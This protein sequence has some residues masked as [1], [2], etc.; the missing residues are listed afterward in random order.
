MVEDKKTANFRNIIMLGLVS[1]FIDMSTEMVYPIIPLFLVS[2]GTAPYIIG[3]IEGVAESIAALLRSFAG[4][5]TDKYNS[6]K[7]LTI[8]G[9]S[10]AVVYKLGLLFSATWIGVL[11][12]RIV[13][14]TGKGLRTAPRD[15]LIA[16]AGGKKL[17]GSFG[18]HKMFDMLGA[19]L[20][21]LLAYI[22]LSYDFEY[23]TIIIISIIPAM[24]GVAI[25][26]F[27]KEVKKEISVK[28]KDESKIR[29]RLD[30]KLVFYLIVIFI[31]S[32]GTSSK[33]FL[34]LKATSGGF[35][36]TSILLLY[37]LLNTT[38]SV[39]SIPF[40]KLSDKWGRKAMVIPSYILYAVVYF[41]FAFFTGTAA[42]ITLFFFYGLYTA[43]ISGAER[44]LLVE[45]SPKGLKGTVLGIYG[46]MQGLGLLLSSTVAGLLWSFQ[47][48]SSPFI[49][50]GI[51][52][53]VS[54]I[55]ILLLG[56]GNKSHKSGIN[57]A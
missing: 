55:L 56:I 21:V 49:L 3:V 38:A 45:M 30:R 2:L 57:Q 42:M 32:I 14:R 50:G 27:V 46:T 4:Y 54:A 22:I 24:I 43:M 34:L 48:D 53:I 31:F 44:A 39:F 41:G 19:A 9:Y 40:G 5:L 36:S 47:G 26:F 33:A 35:D 7:P 6:K 11:F 52:A 20:G 51:I 37:L 12:S 29:I 15:S 28:N 10:A 13:D 16:E 8:I 1:L 18:L 17:G 23:K 25:L